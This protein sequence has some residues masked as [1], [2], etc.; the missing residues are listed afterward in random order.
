M[1]WRANAKAR[2]VLE[3]RNSAADKDCCHPAAAV[4]AFLEE[5]AR[6]DRVADEGKRSGGGRDQAHIGMA[7]RKEKG[8]EGDCHGGEAGEK[9][10]I[11]QHR[12]GCAE[13]A[14]ARF[15]DIEIADLTER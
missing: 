11:T 13:K 6:S 2:L 12:K 14:A 5:D 3:E 9:A 10:R 7:Q 15:D 8:E 4:D 1:Q